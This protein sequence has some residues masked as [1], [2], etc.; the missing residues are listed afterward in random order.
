MSRLKSSVWY[1]TWLSAFRLCSFVSWQ[2]SSQGTTDYHQKTRCEEP[3]RQYPRVWGTLF[4]LVGPG[5]HLLQPE[6]PRPLCGQGCGQGG[7]RGDPPEE[8]H[9]HHRNRQCY[10]PHP[11]GGRDSPRLP[12]SV[13]HRDL[14][15]PGRQTQ[16][17]SQQ[18]RRGG[19]S[20]RRCPRESPTMLFV[21]SRWDT[22]S[23]ASE[24]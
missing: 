16:G 10:L 9:C 6:V 7:P 8:Q 2:W 13:L 1:K 21:C 19:P 24:K 12:G 3:L 18:V 20:M 4:F 17:A 14:E 22:V 23:D 5:Q 11:S 15:I